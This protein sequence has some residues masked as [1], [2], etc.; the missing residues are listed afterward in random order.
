MKFPHNKFELEQ[1]GRDSHEVEENP[2]L[3]ELEQARLS[4]A[5][6]LASGVAEYLQIK[7][8]KGAH[9]LVPAI[10]EGV[11]VT[12]AAKGVHEITGEALNRYE[13]TVDILNAVASATM[14]ICLMLGKYDKAAIAK[15]AVISLTWVEPALREAARYAKELG[16]NLGDVLERIASST[17]LVQNMVGIFNEGEFDDAFEGE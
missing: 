6:R 2:E 4:L 11:L 10:G 16:S 13:R 7:F 14:W 12:R 5:R 3:A 17:P 1:T 15:G 9:T 8:E